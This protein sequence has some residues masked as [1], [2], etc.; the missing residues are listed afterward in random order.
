[1]NVPCDKR[2]PIP[3]RQLTVRLLSAAV[4]V[5]LLA[6]GCSSEVTDK[7]ATPAAAAGR[8]IDPATTGSI[9]GQV[10][11]EGVVPPADVIRMTT[12][13]KCLTDA[14][15]NPKSDALI[16]AED[17]SVANAFVY[18]KDG[19][20]PAYTFDVPT[21][22][23]VLD[24][25]GCIYTPRVLG[26]RVG[27]AIAIVNSDPTMHNVHALPMGNREFNHG[28]PK[29]FTRVS[30]VFTTPEVMVRFKCDVHSWMSAW[31]GVLPHPYFAVTDKAG[32]FALPKLP[33]GSYTLEAW[34]EKLGR[35]TAQVTIAPGQQQSTSLT[36]TAP[37]K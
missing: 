30:E 25:R 7:P 9:T 18:I 32:A 3:M 37:A 23:A 35:Q 8:K 12:D 17:K 26:V 22:P 34:H 31:V 33:P 6:A 29:Q 15:P 5:A 19:L 24:Q 21:E 2:S 1:M 27:Q 20:D 11:F 10:R 14:G 28:Q 16:V 13:K 4:C 36:F